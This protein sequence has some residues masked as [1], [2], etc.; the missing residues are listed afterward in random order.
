MFAVAVNAVVVVLGGLIGTL[1]GKLLKDKYASAI[2]TALGLCTL[3]IGFSGALKGENV[4]IAI[5]AMVLGA[6]VG[7][8]LNLDGA[9][10]RLGER[11]QRLTR[12]RYG[13][14]AEGFVTASL[15]FCVGAMSV[16]GSLEAG[17]SAKF[18][19][20]YAKSALDFAA[21]I[22][23]ASTLGL[24]VVLSAFTILVYQGAIA[25]L[26]GLIAPLLSVSAINEMTCVGSL[27]IIALGL[28]LLKIGSFK[29]ADLL[30]AILIAPALVSIIALF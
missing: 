4:L 17:L 21:A 26:A 23:L 28:N 29:V 8:A 15:L 20:L 30:P 6:L 9:I 12:A 1:F 14:V 19:T 22:M 25:L 18:D 16:T 27:L 7:T 24:G 13:Q 11:A 2:M 10:T 3:Y 5:A